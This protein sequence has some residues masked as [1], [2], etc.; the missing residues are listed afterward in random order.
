MYLIGLIQNR[1]KQHTRA[2]TWGLLQ[3]SREV[4]AGMIRKKVATSSRVNSH[5]ATAWRQLGDNLA[6]AW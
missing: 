4:V 2:T 5:M 6:T 1:R 3:F